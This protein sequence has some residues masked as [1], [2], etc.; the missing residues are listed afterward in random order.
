M[1][2]NYNPNPARTRV[3][4]CAIR[5]VA[6][7]TEQDWQSAYSAL[8]VKGYE[9]SDL[10]SANN[11]W[12]AYL[13]EKGF[14]RE[15]VPNTCP[16]CYTVRDFCADHPR[17]VFVLALDGHVVTVVDGDHFDTWDSGGETVLYY[18]YKERKS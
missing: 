8:A 4:D 11:V 18:W 15:I 14:R 10:P 9:M 17:G 1:W 16:D 7:A 12:G 3:G 2:V 5:A 6:R 13:R